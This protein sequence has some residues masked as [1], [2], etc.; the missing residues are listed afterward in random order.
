M[1][2]L[3]EELLR[4]E[5]RLVLEAGFEHCYVFGTGGEGYAVDTRRFRQVVDIFHEEVDGKPVSAMVGVIG[6]STVQI[7]ERL[8]YAHDVGFRM[9]QISLPSWGPLDDDEV[10][11][12][13]SDVCGT[14]PDSRFLHYNLPRTKRVLG[15]R[16]YAKIIPVVPNLVATKTTGGGMAGAEELIRHAG[17]LQHFMGE[18]NFPHGAMFG[19]A[20]LL[21]SYA[22]LA[23]RKTYA[24][25]EAGRTGD[26]GELMRL[27]HAFATAGHGPVGQAEARP[28]H[29]RRVRQDAGQARDAPRVPAPP[30]VAVPR[31]RRGRLPGLPALPPGRVRRLARTDRGDRLGM[32]A[33]RGA[34]PT[35]APATIEALRALDAATI[36]NVLK[37][38]GRAEPGSYSGPELRC[39]F[40]ELGTLVGYAVTSEWTGGEPD[41][42]NEDYLALLELIE[43]MPKPVVS[44]LVDVGSRPGRSGIAGDGMMREFQVLGAAGAVVAGSIIDIAGMEK[45]SFPVYATGVVPA[46][47]DM[48][49]AGF[50]HPV[51]VGPLRVVTGDLLVADRTGVLRV[52]VDAADAVIAGL[53]GFRALEASVA[54][55]LDRPGLTA[56]Q[57][58]AWYEQ[59]E[60]AFLGG[61]ESSSETLKRVVRE[62]ATD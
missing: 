6:L 9:F 35:V 61:D 13:F 33:A 45:L 21:A 40:P 58:R 51:D 25:F 44:V 23:P 34:L 20:S 19:E 28:A 48:R 54:E 7:V 10:L 27:Q 14:F 36:Y 31:L 42:P 37:G 24:L 30:A 22:E 50:G 49:M 26:A 52:P 46:Y 38:L 43:S 8:E 17:E 1:I 16:D 32:T 47:D 62:A 57:M 60:P 5:V 29:G 15:G 4:E 41:A 3:I 18:G 56:A 11:R 39:L 12:F 2:E 53:P 55:L 59:N